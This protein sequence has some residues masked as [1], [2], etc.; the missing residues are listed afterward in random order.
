MSLIT[1]LD[2]S[3]LKKNCTFSTSH[4]PPS[5]G[6]MWWMVGPT[7][8]ETRI[9][10]NEEWIDGEKVGLLKAAAQSDSSLTLLEDPRVSC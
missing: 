8:H 3:V 10:G 4:H 6:L 7:A 2:S 5:S 1:A 9:D